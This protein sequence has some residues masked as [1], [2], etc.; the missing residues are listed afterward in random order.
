MKRRIQGLAL[1]VMAMLLLPLF[2]VAVAVFCLLAAVAMPIVGLMKPSILLDHERRRR[3]TA[4]EIEAAEER[5]Q[6]EIGRLTRIAKAATAEG[7][8]SS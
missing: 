3:S 4:G 1:G 6:A 5:V 8:V 7:E 2:G